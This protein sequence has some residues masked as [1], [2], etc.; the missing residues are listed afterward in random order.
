[1]IILGKTPSILR[2]QTYLESTNEE[3]KNDD[4][5]ASESSTAQKLSEVATHES[6][7][8]FI[9]ATLFSSPDIAPN[10][11]DQ[12]ESVS[13][14][15]NVKSDSSELMSSLSSTAIELPEQ[16]SDG[17]EYIIGFIAKKFHTKY[18]ELQ[19]G[20]YTLN[21][22]SDHSYSHPPSFL[23]HLS[24]GGLFAPSEW[25]LKQGYKME[26]IFQKMHPNGVFRQKK[27]IMKKL[28]KKIAVN[29]PA[30]PQDI[31]ASFVKHRV[32]VRIRYMNIK[33][34]SEKS[35]HSKRKSEMQRKHDNKIR[36]LTS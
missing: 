5:I 3:N 26:K 10:F 27:A 13:V 29:M 18:P 1:M 8:D 34:A 9:S 16:D 14:N 15:E 4:H 21:L 20:T 33:I 22:S 24:V 35:I 25:F 2:N 36:K 11:P 12:S 31:I 28:S 17:L 7:E 32:N 6:N 30:L 23:K 19:L